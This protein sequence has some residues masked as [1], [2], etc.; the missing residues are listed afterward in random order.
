MVAGAAA[1]LRALQEETLRKTLGC[2]DG[3]AFQI[4]ER[5]KPGACGPSAPMAFTTQPAVLP[6]RISVTGKQWVLR[7]AGLWRG[8]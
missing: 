4:T 6:D 3:F 1:S 5:W 8:G 7:E 2:V